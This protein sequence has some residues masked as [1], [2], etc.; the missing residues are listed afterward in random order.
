MKITRTIKDIVAQMKKQ[1][2]TAL[3]FLKVEFI[4]KELFKYGLNSALSDDPRL[5]KKLQ[6][7]LESF[8]VSQ[9]QKSL[10]Y[11]GYN[12]T[13]VGP[14]TITHPKS[15]HI[16]NNVI[17]GRESHFDSRAGI[18]I[19]DNVRMSDNTTIYTSHPQFD[20][21][22]LPHDISHT[23][24]PV[25]IASNVWIGKNTTI[26]PGVS[27][28]EGA[29]I[30]H[31][32]V[33]SSNVKAY[34]AV[35]SVKTLVDGYRDTTRYKR[36]L[37]RKAFL[38]KNGKRLPGSELKRFF[39]SANDK[40][41]KMFFVIST[42]RSGTTTVAKALS[43]HSKIICQHE[44]KIQLIKISTDL[45][46][47]QISEQQATDLLEILYTDCSNLPKGIY[48][49]SD[50]KLSNLTEILSR[51]LPHSKFIWLI[52]NPIDTINSTYSRGWFSDHELGHLG[53]RKTENQQYRH[54]YSDYRP[55]GDKTGTVS[56]E[57][58]GQMDSFERNC[59]Y[60]FFWNHTIETQLD[61]INKTR[62]IKVNLDNL[63]EDIPGVLSLLGAPI[64]DIAIPTSNATESSHHLVEHSN[65]NTSMKNSFK[66]WRDHKFI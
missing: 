38:G 22:L 41:E 7:K 15:M 34:S 21:D 47:G 39:V 19:G 8:E 3:K 36:N 13:L 52:R 50:H 63:S 17:I 29:I 9:T 40:A 16:G 49:E 4:V 12:L 59:W 30:E 57:E 42:G 35:G 44:P 28:G 45:L 55:R 23:I 6:K 64:E 37:E 51:L 25:S 11:S 1:L 26:L 33:V 27:I 18:T 48:G 65:W 58:W 14:I 60:Y 5:L 53:L 20:G 24:K 54:L 32:T 10:K 56:K 31:G 43:Q 62:W 2:K 66:K 61:T 46:H